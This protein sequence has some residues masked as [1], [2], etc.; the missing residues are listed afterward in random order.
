MNPGRSRDQ[1]DHPKP[2]LPCQNRQCPENEV[3]F[4]ELAWKKSGQFLLE[5][6]CDKCDSTQVIVYNWVSGRALH[7]AIEVVKTEEVDGETLTWKEWIT[8]KSIRVGHFVNGSFR[9]DIGSFHLANKDQKEEDEKY[10]I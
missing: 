10:E 2:K 8:P 1:T 6:I 5:G 7:R 3:H 9:I 4:R